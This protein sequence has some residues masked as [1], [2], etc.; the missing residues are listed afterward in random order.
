MIDWWDKYVGMPLPRYGI[1]WSTT[2]Y[3]TYENYLKSILK[4]K[5]VDNT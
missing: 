4:E 2:K 3:E 1:D 5:P